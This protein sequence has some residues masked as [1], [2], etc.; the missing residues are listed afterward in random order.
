[1][2]RSVWCAWRSA[3]VGRQMKMGGKWGQIKEIRLMERKGAI[4]THLSMT[5]RRETLIVPG[6]VTCYI[7]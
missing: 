6:D 5:V 7:F 3:V 1:M 4:V 2:Q